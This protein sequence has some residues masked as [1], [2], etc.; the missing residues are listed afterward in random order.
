M[1]ARYAME[2]SRCTGL[3]ETKVCGVFANC[4]KGDA[5][6]SYTEDK[7]LLFADGITFHVR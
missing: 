4:V 5:L 6:S 1:A 3:A 2:L 7:L